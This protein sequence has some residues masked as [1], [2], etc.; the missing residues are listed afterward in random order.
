M[1]LHWKKRKQLSFR[2]CTAGLASSARFGKA[3]WDSTDGLSGKKSQEISR[4]SVKHSSS[5]SLRVM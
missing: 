3:M 2:V 4:G 1:E 5:T